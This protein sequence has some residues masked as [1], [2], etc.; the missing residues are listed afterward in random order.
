MSKCKTLCP[1]AQHDWDGVQLFA[2][3]KGT[4]ERPE[5]VYLDQPRSVTDEV[6]ELAGPVVPEA[7][8]R[9]SAPCIEAECQHFDDDRESCR[10]AER[11]IRLAH[12]APHKLSRCA[13]RRSCL[14]WQ[15]EGYQACQR[16]P[17]VVMANYTRS[18]EIR[19][20][21]RN[22]RKGLP[23]IIPQHVDC[24]VQTR[25]PALWVRC[26]RHAS[27]MT[28]RDARLAMDGQNG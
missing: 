5:A 12:I 23:S 26:D 20:G 7:L 24:H 27:C 22:R 8:F 15:Q 13:I 25:R 17:Q 2:L 19:V 18:P 1:S 14:W 11:A 6:L 3:V 21:D 4:L 16:C 9:F 28:Q 10:L